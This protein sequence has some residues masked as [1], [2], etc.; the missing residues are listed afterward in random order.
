VKVFCVGELYKPGVTRYY[1][2]T[3][4]DFLQSG[5]VLE[6]Y[7]D[8]PMP[9]EIKAISQSYNNIENDASYLKG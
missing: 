3:R 7:I 6:I 1:E 2:G 8:N 9:E 5:A 4:F